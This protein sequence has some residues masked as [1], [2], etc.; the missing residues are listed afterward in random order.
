[1]MPKVK[2]YT[3]SEVAEEELMHKTVH[4]GPVYIQG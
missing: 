1:M 4:G 2:L 3:V